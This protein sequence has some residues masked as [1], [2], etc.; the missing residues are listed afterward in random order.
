MFIEEILQGGGPLQAAI[1]EQ[2]DFVPMDKEIYIEREKG[3]EKVGV[4]FDDLVVSEV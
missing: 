2:G 3:R 4:I 1:K